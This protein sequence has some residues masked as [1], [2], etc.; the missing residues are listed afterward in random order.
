[1]L[2]LKSLTVA[3]IGRFVEE[4]TINF[5][6]LNDLVQVEGQNNNTGGSSGAGKSTIFKSLEFLLGLNDISNGILQSRL[7][8]SLMSVTGIFELDGVPLKIV[9]DKKLLID[10]NGEVTT[11]SSKLSEEKLDKIIGMD[12]A[13]FRKILIKRQGEQGFFLNFGPSETHKF[14]TNCLGLE[15]EQ[16][17][18]ATLDTK[19]TSLESNGASTRIVVES[20]ESALKATEIATSALGPSPTLEIVPEIIEALVAKHLEAVNTHRL[21]LKSHK[22]EMEALERSR[23]QVLTIPFDRSNIEKLE[24]QV[25][26]IIFQISELEKVEINRQSQ[27]RSQISELQI[28]IND[29]NNKELNRQSEVKSRISSLQS[30][31]EKLNSA[32]LTRQA[33]VKTTIS[34]LR[35]ELQKLQQAEKDR[36]AQVQ[37]FI[38]LNKI[39]QIKAQALIDEG[40]KIKEEAGKL[41]EELKKVRASLCPTCEQSWINEAAKT[42]EVV[43]LGKLQEYKRAVVSGI[44]A[45]ADLLVLVDQRVKLDQE[46]IPKDI[47][48]MSKYLEDFK[49]LEG[50]S[51]PQISPEIENIN[52][53]I[54]QLKLEFQPQ[55]VQEA[56]EL[57]Y[58]IEHLRKNEELSALS[59]EVV[60]LKKHKFL[61]EQMLGFERKVESEHQFKESA[62]QQSILVEYAKKQNDIR[63]LNESAINVARNQENAV[64]LELQTA[65]NKVVNFKE[66]KKRFEESLDKLNAQLS[67]YSNMFREHNTKLD[68]IK[69]E[70]EL[71]TELK[72]AIKSYLSCSFEDALDSIGDTATKLIKSI[73][74]MANATVQFEGLRE[75]KEGKIKEEVVC[76]VSMDGEIGV[77]IKSLS[78]GERSSTDLAVDL[79]V[80]KFIEERTG[81]GCNIMCLDEPF[82]GL[83]SQNIMEALEM[84]K[85]CNS[86]KQILIVDHNPIASQSIENKIVVIRDGLTSRIVQQ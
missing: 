41:A 76:T 4:Q 55:V 1:M 78:G 86:E 81:K 48:E 42:K 36:Q 5:D 62:R 70:I 27:V 33:E 7:T 40:N 34:Y 28:K 74:N 65:Q 83:D 84:L 32:E 35:A 75:T 23:P 9:R 2:I 39:D 52:V 73:P 67:L 85:A 6:Q 19:L 16:A 59:S 8:K 22:A 44:K 69:E 63:E 46:A 51:Q 20:Y 18:I 24:G 37:S 12:R 72:K 21:V 15:K 66:S 71:A 25:G 64:L 3:N 60:E 11:G 53:Q 50:L 56:V 58:K 31:I 47:P 79:A 49:K 26:S 13:L 57:S 68:E 45:S 61:Q 80:V 17:K 29:L 82:T 38:S 10:L 30:D 54:A 14:L 43:I 77:P